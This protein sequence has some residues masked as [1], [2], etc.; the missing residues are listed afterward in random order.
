MRTPETTSQSTPSRAV[1]RWPSEAYARALER[2]Y[3]SGKMSVVPKKRGP[4]MRHITRW[5]L[6]VVVGVAAISV[7]L[8]RKAIFGPHPNLQA[9]ATFQAG[10]REAEITSLAT[11]VL[12]GMSLDEKVGQLIIPMTK[13]LGE[14]QTMITQ[15]HIG[16]YFVDS[17]GMNA[18]QLRAYLSQLQSASRIP[19]IMS[20]DFEGDQ[21]FDQ[22]SSALPAQPSEAQVGATGDPHQAYLKGVNDGKALASVGINV[23][24]G[25]V[26]DVLTNPNNP[27]LGGRTYGNTPD[28]VTK[29]AGQEIDGLTSVGVASTIKHFPGLGSSNTD[30]H[31]SLPTI[32]RTLA[33][34]Q[35]TELVPYK[36]LIA[37]G[38]VS[39]IMTTHMLIDALDPNLPT[40]ISPAVIN[41]L[42]RQQMGYNGVVVSD[43][44][45][46][47]GLAYKW[48]TPH[49]GLLAFE[50]GTDLLL[51][52]DQYTTSDYDT[53]TTITLIKQAIARGDITMAQLDASVLR[54]LK[55]K[56][57]WNIIPAN[58]TLPGNST[59]NTSNAQA[60]ALALS[61]AAD[62]TR[63]DELRR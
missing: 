37:Q 55:F 41:G 39:M 6:T 28:Y 36:D 24:F 45:F 15:D 31:H 56:A 20:T 7:V 59:A 23:D 17:E 32:N 40:S 29:M 34:M 43:A 11:Q 30:P 54:I 27:I 25:P 53:R 42:L 52:A 26:V 12:S 44:L 47:G 51:G 38:K 10:A 14:L 50:A 57:Q 58:F 33:E 2:A 4:D 9:Q 13:N 63:R 49:A 3:T 61:H 62:V 35:Q 60:P 1:Q 18:N 48:D 8:N 46:M 22:V 16:G 19:L 5:L 21:G